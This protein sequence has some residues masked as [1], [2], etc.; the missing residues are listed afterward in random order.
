[1]DSCTSVAAK[2]GLRPS[3]VSDMVRDFVTKLRVLAKAK[4]ARKQTNTRA[5]LEA[6]IEQL[7]RDRQ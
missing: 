5:N 3:L 7:L 4:F 2:M 6:E 1:M